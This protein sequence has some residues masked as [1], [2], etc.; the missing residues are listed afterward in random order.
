MVRNQRMLAE[1]ERLG[2]EPGVEGVCVAFPGGRGT[3]DMVRRVRQ[4]GIRIEKGGMR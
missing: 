1:V 3:E 2:K 4:A